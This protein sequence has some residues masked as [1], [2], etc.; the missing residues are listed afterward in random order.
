MR[1][2]K[3]PHSM[4]PNFSHNYCNA[5]VPNTVLNNPHP[6]RHIYIYI[7]I[8]LEH[9]YSKMEEISTPLNGS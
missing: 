2:H 1:V 6:Q 3:R 4:Q 5:I 7:Y 8:Q 9:L